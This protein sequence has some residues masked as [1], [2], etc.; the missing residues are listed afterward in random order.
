MSKMIEKIRNAQFNSGVARSLLRFAYREGEN[1]K[2]PIGPLR[3]FRLFYDRSVNFHAMLGLWDL[4]SFRFLRSLLAGGG[5]LKPGAVV[6]DVGAN[7]G[8]F[9][10]WASRLLSDCQG[11]VFAFEP[12]PGTKEMLLKNLSLNGIVNVEL[13]DAAC[14]N[15]EGT[16][17]FFPGHHHH[18]SS[19]CAEWAAFGGPIPDKVTVP[20]VTLDNF[21]FGETK[22]PAPDFLK[23][24]IEGGGCYALYGM[25]RCLEEKR[26]LIW[27][28]SH[29]PAEDQAIGELMVRNDYLAFRNQTKSFVKKVERTHP[30]P[31]GVWG[32]MLLFPREHYTKIRGLV[33]TRDSLTLSS[34]LSPDGTA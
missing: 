12:A 19:L 22:R 33:S 34:E 6:A 8:I 1:Y 24:D 17:D 20:T 31:E 13:V 4:D 11:K 26:P 5:Y 2:I 16:I 9:S 7:I 10:M 27:M 14:S 32:T 3:G 21:F 29:T 25:D 30:D 23:I 28:E 15:R 18:T